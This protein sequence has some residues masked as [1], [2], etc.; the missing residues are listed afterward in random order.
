[1][2]NMLLSSEPQNLKKIL[3]YLTCQ[4][5][6]IVG[7]T[8]PCGPENK[9]FLYCFGILISNCVV[10]FYVAYVKH[11]NNIIIILV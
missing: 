2:E 9:S 4:S 11:I 8:F 6:E 1:M 5:K 3:T 7:N 10:V